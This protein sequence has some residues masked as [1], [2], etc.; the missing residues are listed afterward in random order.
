MPLP[1]PFSDSS[2]L[3]ETNGTRGLVE[4]AKSNVLI[5]AE[6]VFQL[7]PRRA[8]REMRKIGIISAV[9]LA[10]SV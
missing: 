8:T 4:V 5:K 2:S 3:L 9:E 6:Q 1:S 10:I 7:C